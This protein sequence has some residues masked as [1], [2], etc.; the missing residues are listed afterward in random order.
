M[1]L[2]SGTPITDYCDAHRLHPQARIDLFVAVCQ[3]VQHAH[4][5][6]IIHRDLK[7]SNVLIAE[8]DGKPVPKVID[9]GVAKA[10]GHAIQDQTIHSIIGML[11][12]TLEYMSP[13]QAHL[14]PVDVDTRSDV[15]SL[16]VLLYELLTGTTPLQRGRIKAAAV[17]EVLRVIREEEP[18]KP[19]TRLSDLRDSVAS[20]SAQRHSEPRHLTKLLQGELDWIVMKSLEKDRSRRYES[21]NSFALDLQ[22]YL[23]HEP[24]EA[25]PPSRW[26]R[27]KKF[28]RRHRLGVTAAALILLTLIGGIIGTSYGLVQANESRKLAEDRFNI[29]QEAVSEFL[30]KVTDDPDLKKADFSPLRKRLLNLAVPFYQ[31]L[32]EQKP[33]SLKQ[34]G[35][36]AEALNRLGNI[37]FATGEFDAAEAVL[38]QARDE[39]TALIAEQPAARN[40]QASLAAIYNGLGNVYF[41][42]G[43]NPQALIDYAE[44]QRRY[45]ELT[46]ADPDNAAFL[47]SLANCLNNVGTVLRL[48]GE[49]KKAME[50]YGESRERF[51]QLIAAHP[52]AASYRLNQADLLTHM[53]GILQEQVGGDY[54]KAKLFYDEARSSLEALVAK[55]PSPESRLSLMTTLTSE[56][57]LLTAFHDHKN[58]RS[59]LERSCHLGEELVR[60][61]P[62]IPK[63]RVSLGFAYHDLGLYHS[64]VNEKDAARAAYERACVVRER[65]ATDFPMIPEYRI[66]LG[67]TYCNLGIVDNE[68]GRPES[69][70]VWYGKAKK[71]I[72]EALQHSESGIRGKQYLFNVLRNRSYI[73]ENGGHWTEAAQEVE[74]AIDLTPPADRLDMRLR[75]ASLLAHTNNHPKAVVVASAVASEKNVKSIEVLKAAWVCCLACE[76]VKEDQKEVRKYT[77]QSMTLLHQAADLGV[78]RDERVYQQ[79]IADKDF[80]PLR[81]HP[82]FRAW[83]SELEKTYL[84]PK[85]K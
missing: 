39:Y 10:L 72:E 64:S 2:V 19:S 68:Q 40:Q 3:A 34:R 25:G 50:V 41:R 49:T 44:A 75:Y 26:Y 27:V 9:F 21:A 79:L 54:Q 56:G 63:N 23:A 15:Y 74:H 38:I 20:I 77:N 12:G 36:H 48:Q 78:F 7:P 8:Y 57:L 42:L 43:K 11:V 6:G 71:V 58:A 46:A 60:D 1:E 22:R 18:P 55:L 59:L 66:E 73:F 24:V 82:D 31:R 33:T 28:V 4:Q 17:D 5:K 69:A 76:Q 35:D 84:V 61:F 81:S 37:R 80:A 30:D 32:V 67:G 52:D 13:E 47:L 65:L 45:V 51:E 62:S 83:A 70:L 16:G 29:A 14:N 53:A 85:S